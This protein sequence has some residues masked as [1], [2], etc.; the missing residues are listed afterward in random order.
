MPG[1]PKQIDGDP[2]GGYFLDQVRHHSIDAAVPGGCQE[3]SDVWNL[4][5]NN[6]FDTSLG[7]PFSVLK[8]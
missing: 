3:N 4:S 2:S 6:H 1:N 8:S 5:S 7:K